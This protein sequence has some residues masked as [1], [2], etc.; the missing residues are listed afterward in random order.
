MAKGC[1]GQESWLLE[2]CPPLPHHQFFPLLLRLT[3]IQD[4]YGGVPGGSGSE[5]SAALQGSGAGGLLPDVPMCSRAYGPSGAQIAFSQI[6][7]K[8]CL[9]QG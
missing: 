8:R 5:A 7:L 3:Q 1:F 2:S 4:E 6:Q 9:E